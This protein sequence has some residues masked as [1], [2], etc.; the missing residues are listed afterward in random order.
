M[1]PVLALF[2]RDLTAGL[3]DE[4]G[5][6]ARGTWSFLRTMNDFVVQPLLTVTTSKGC[7]VKEALI[8]F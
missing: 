2:S 7:N 4:N 8:F 1:P 6:A 3:E 5:E